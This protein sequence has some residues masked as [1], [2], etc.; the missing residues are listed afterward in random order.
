MMNNSHSGPASPP[1]MLSNKSETPKG[2]SQEHV[3]S[4]LKGEGVQIILPPS[5]NPQLSFQIGNPT[6]NLGVFPKSTTAHGK[7]SPKNGFGYVAKHQSANPFKQTS[8][9]N[10][11]STN[12]G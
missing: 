10:P 3:P 7:S 6:S 1:Q 12:V 11:V 9:G 4:L 8:S 5:S 2:G